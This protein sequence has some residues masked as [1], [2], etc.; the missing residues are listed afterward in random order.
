MDDVDVPVSYI[1]HSFGPVQP[2]RMTF[3][4]YTIGYLLE[5]SKSKNKTDYGKR[6]ADN[7][8]LQHDS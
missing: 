6:Q 1:F 7:D 2:R 4:A 8:Q 5:H 3:R